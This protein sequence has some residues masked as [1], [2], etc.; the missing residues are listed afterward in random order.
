MAG[1]VEPVELRDKK[2]ATTEAARVQLQKECDD[3]INKLRKARDEV[4]VAKD[5]VEDLEL[6]LEQLKKDMEAKNEET[7]ASTIKDLKK[8]EEVDRL[9]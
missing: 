9:K 3:T 7:R 6:E 2:L 8:F 4:G 1:L 5:E